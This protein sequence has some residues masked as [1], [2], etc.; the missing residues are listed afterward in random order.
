MLWRAL[1]AAVNI[2]FHSVTL[3]SI[4]KRTMRR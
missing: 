2:I 3:I 4:I 1:Q